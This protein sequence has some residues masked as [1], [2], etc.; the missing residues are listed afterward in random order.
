MKIKITIILTKSLNIIFVALVSAF[1]ER[2]SQFP[3]FHI[4][5]GVSL[6]FPLAAWSI[7]SFY[8]FGLYAGAGI[9]I[10]SILMPWSP[11]TP[12]HQSIING[13]IHCLEG[14]L[15]YFV[16]KAK[17]A[18]IS[19]QKH[20]TI[21][22][23]LGIGLLLGTWFNA[24]FG[25]IYQYL[26]YGT[27]SGDMVLRWFT[28][29]T[30]DLIAA[31]AFAL[32]FLLLIQPLLLKIPLKIKNLFFDKIHKKPHTFKPFKVKL[33]LKEYFLFTIVFLLFWA[34]SFI[35]F[36]ASFEM[37]LNWFAVLFLFPVLYMAIKGGFKGSIYFT[38]ITAI[39]LLTLVFIHGIPQQSPTLLVTLYLNLLV[40]FFAGSI[41]GILSEA[42][43]LKISEIE[44]LHNFA[45]QL[46]VKKAAPEVLQDLAKT[47][48][49]A[50]QLKG[51][52]IKAT[53]GKV[54]TFPENLNIEGDEARQKMLIKADG[55]TF[56]TLELI[57]NGP[58]PFSEKSLQLAESAIRQ[59]AIALDNTRIYESLEFK[60]KE[61]KALF[62][63]AKILLVTLDL[64][65]ILKRTITSLS[66][67]F[68]LSIAYIFL[69][70]RDGNLSLKAYSG[71]EPEKITITTLRPGEG[72][73]GN[74]FASGKIRY[75][76]NVEED[77]DYIN[78]VPG[79][80]SQL[81]IPLN[82]KE[83]ILGVLSLESYL[84]DAFRAE[85]I[86]LLKAVSAQLSLAI[87]QVQLHNELENAHISLKDTYFET[88]Q[89]LCN[90]VEAKDKYTQGHVER[91]ATYAL[92]V[93][94]RMGLSEDRLDILR[95]AAMLHDI[96]KIGI[97][98][99]LLQKGA[100]FTSRE[101][102]I[103]KRH[104]EIGVQILQEIDFL[105]PALPAIYYHQ[106]WYSGYD[107]VESFGYPVG[108]KG[109]EIP[110][111]ARI[112]CVVDSFDA[113]TSTRP[114]RKALPWD[115]AV[116]RLIID[117]GRQ[118]DP[119]IVDVFIDILQSSYNY[120]LPSELRY[121]MLL[122]PLK[123][124][125]PKGYELSEPLPPKLT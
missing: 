112:I 6:F 86:Q 61:L 93:G 13:L 48:F 9:I 118:F 30:S 11:D 12:L 31:F 117:K 7:V 102:E 52:I 74:V 94:I 76:P 37:T 96:G 18:D 116:K 34:L 23:F 106:E 104:V 56:G 119:K 43:A 115:E 111:E 26:R 113:M 2:I 25:S 27:L 36:S 49:E 109:E 107:G 41:S 91:T 103:I 58:S 67:A 32:P 42:N 73:I 101:R 5:P 53:E 122:P 95:L 17:G 121:L 120:R 28:R 84:P 65:E 110:L 77:P 15:P 89:A 69:K 29:W 87:K 85:D 60:V 108:L 123:G 99:D 44:K 3:A 70:N 39:G 14:V 66:Q 47:L 64:N 63:V 68:H 46:V 35:S 59:A 71:I 100:Y 98:E 88:M 105:K 92:E 114:Y 83:E 16:L 79:V 72:I 4:I 22:K 38:A 50:L 82:V 75:A 57:K 124:K 21:I 80:Y 62:D 90:A 33:T 54:Q 24:T 51:V 125:P 78:M 81:A 1:F 20:R 8:F 19:L 55:M 45:S 40:I 10:G 97:P